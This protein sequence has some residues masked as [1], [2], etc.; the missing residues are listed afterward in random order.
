M[1][2][3]IK[4]TTIYNVD[5][6][7]IPN[8]PVNGWG[9]IFRMSDADAFTYQCLFNEGEEVGRVET[10]EDDGDWAIVAYDANSRNLGTFE[11]R[12]QAREAVENAQGGRY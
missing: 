2:R 11:T 5:S 10:W 6:P 7:D 3:L 1:K 9:P 8:D 4:A 12:E